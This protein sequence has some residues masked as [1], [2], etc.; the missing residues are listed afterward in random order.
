MSASNSHDDDDEGAEEHG[1]QT[2]R[3]SSGCYQFFGIKS[4]LHHFYDYSNEPESEETRLFLVPTKKAKRCSPII[5]KILL[6]FGINSL[7]F[8]AILILV[9]HFTPRQALMHPATAD[10]R[11]AIVDD[12]ASRINAALDILGTVGIVS[13]CCAGVLIVVAVLLPTYFK[14]F[15]FENRDIETPSPPSAADSDGRLNS[16]EAV[17]IEQKIPATHL[18]KGV[19]PQ[20]KASESTFDTNYAPID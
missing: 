9:S 2:E 3:A 6:W 18:L 5:W 12:R 20:R 1:K 13:F 4:H 11:F 15:C 14:E 10:D 19:Q 16:E 7:V 8:G 17:N